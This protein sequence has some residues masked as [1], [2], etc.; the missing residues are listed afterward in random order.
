MVLAFDAVKK[1]YRDNSGEVP[2]L[3]GISFELQQG[4][5]LALTGESGSGKSTV[6]HI[7]GGLEAPSD[8]AV[9]LAGRDLAKM[10]DSDRAGMRRSEVSLVFQ[11]FNLIPSL[12]VATN[13]SFQ[14]AL[15]ERVDKA[16]IERLVKAL[17]L[18]AQLQKYP[19]ALSGGQQQRVAIARALAAK[20]KLLLADEPT[21]NLD[22][23]TAE[24]VLDQML[25]LV[26]ETGAA[27]MVVTHSPKIAA[28]MDRELRLHGGV[29]T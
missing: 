14:A 13:I 27:L 21:G 26:A 17:G 12:T 20:P 11:Q 5:T 3:R 25:D 22:E 9:Q 7:A 23:A 16:Y 19:E 24:G 8:G 2:V 1:S 6:L 18:S 28:R 29:V 10:D 4:K 15:A